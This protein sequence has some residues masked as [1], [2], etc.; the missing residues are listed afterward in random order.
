MFRR[1][2]LRLKYR[3]NITFGNQDHADKE[4]YFVLFGIFFIMLIPSFIFFLLSMHIHTSTK[5]NVAP[6]YHQAITKRVTKEKDAI[7]NRTE[8][9]K[10]ADA[11]INAVGANK[12]KDYFPIRLQE[13][14][15]DPFLLYGIK[16]VGYNI[17]YQS[18]LTSSVNNTFDSTSDLSGSDYW[19][20]QTNKQF[21][22]V[23][24]KINIRDTTDNITQEI[25]EITN[26]K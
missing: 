13:K 25:D 3:T 22:K 10:A 16:K 19:D 7:R 5:Y 17:P 6:S 23:K 24:D 9:E 12:R 8:N 1:L 15:N 11:L 20:K 14:I 21:N 2:G 4:A 18:N 26:N